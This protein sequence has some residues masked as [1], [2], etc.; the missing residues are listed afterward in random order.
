MN[1]T[2]CTAKNRID[3]NYSNGKEG[4]VCYVEDLFLKMLSH[5]ADFCDTIVQRT[6]TA[7]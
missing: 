3:E 1:N 4:V 7:A 2:D 6:E 5:M